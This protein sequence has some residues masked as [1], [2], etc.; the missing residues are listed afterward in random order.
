MFIKSS[1]Q[2]EW[3]AFKL[4]TNLPIISNQIVIENDSYIAYYNLW[5]ITPLTYILNLSR[6]LVY[7]TFFLI[8]CLS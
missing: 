5:L 3:Y 6:S 7:T 2:I 1:F 8:T 4:T